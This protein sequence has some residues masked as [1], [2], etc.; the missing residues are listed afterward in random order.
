M[1]QQTNLKYRI[2]KDKV[3]K[4]FIYLF[5]MLST[6]PLIL[7]FIYIIGKGISAIN[8]EF[9]VELPKPPGEIGGGIANALV[10]SFL[11]ILLSVVMAV[12]PAIAL[13][14]YL[15][16]DK[17][18][19]LAKWVRNAVEVL[20]GIPSIVLGIIAYVWIVMPMGEFSTFAGAVSLAFMMIPVVSKTTEETL[21]L[22]PN[23]LKEASHALGVPYYKTVLKVILPSG[24]SGIITGV[25]LAVSRIAGE[26]APLLFTAFGN[27]FMNWNVLKPSN[28]LPLL[29]FNYATSPFENW[30]RIAWGASFVL[31][32]AILFLNILSKV[33]SRKWKVKY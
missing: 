4:Y 8:W 13:G 12:P 25:L 2:V 19:K 11:L 6:I 18:T 28:S 23:S 16:E 27:P 9:F 14:I 1:M 20:Q 17:G 32:V 10:G 30:Q 5:T 26:T 33:L 31:I 29:I 22:V 24:L 21:A 7:I 3:F 15:S